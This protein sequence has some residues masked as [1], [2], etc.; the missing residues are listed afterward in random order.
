MVLPLKC[1]GPIGTFLGIGRDPLP[2]LPVFYLLYLTKKILGSQLIS[3]LLYALQQL[4]YALQ[5]QLIVN[6]EKK[7]V[8]NTYI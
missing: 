3:Q 4:L 2:I 5:S 8:V 7:E 6:G 1:L